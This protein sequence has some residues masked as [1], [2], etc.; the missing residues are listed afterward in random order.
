MAVNLA[1][2]VHLPRCMGQLSHFF[3]CE[4]CYVQAQQ[5]ASA[6]EQIA[7]SE[8]LEHELAEAKGRNS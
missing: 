4:Q 7:R 8:R 6:A 2:L 1:D 3:A 5:E